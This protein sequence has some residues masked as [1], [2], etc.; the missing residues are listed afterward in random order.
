MVQEQWRALESAY[1]AGKVRAI[2]VSNYCAACLRCIEAIATVSPHVNQVQLH[3]GMGSADPSAVVSSS[4]AV[5]AVVQAY[6]PLAQS[7]LVS[8]P[9]VGSIA[10]AHGKTPAQV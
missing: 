4:E 9:T 1:F 8:D 7:R 2:G 10:E 3:A 5:G 6:R